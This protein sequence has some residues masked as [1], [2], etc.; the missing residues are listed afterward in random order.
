[1]AF[2]TRLLNGLNVLAAV[3]NA[4]N[5]V[6][7][8]EL[9][10]LT[11][12]AVSRAIQRLESR[13]EVRL[14]ERTSKSVRLTDEGRCFFREAMPLLLRLEE[15]AEGTVRSAG[16]VSG[17]LRVNVEP[18]FARMALAPKLGPFLQMYPGLHLELMIRDRLGDLVADGFDAA[19]RFGEPEPSSLIARRL[20]EVRIITCASPQYL[21]RHGRPFRPTDLV[22]RKHACLLFRNPATGSPYEWE[23]HRGKKRVSISATGPI[24]V[25]DSATYLE[26][27][28]AG[29]G[30]AQMLDFGI[31]PL[32]KN[33][34]LVNL[35]PEWV[36]EKFPLWAYYPSRQF[37]SA[38][39]RLFLDF[40]ATCNLDS[41]HG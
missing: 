7:A 25:N 11:Q 20:C 26:L 30:V 17:R 29:V 35:F 19:V 16:R 18:G 4:G 24:T 23:F 14:L 38:K 33:G 40:L 10:G 34:S 1:M 15:V 5:F 12:S 41:V 9:L 8:G 2:D 37:V 6:R 32:L 22:E 36:D 28:L 31:A 21:G 13:L 39:L 27:C 3:V